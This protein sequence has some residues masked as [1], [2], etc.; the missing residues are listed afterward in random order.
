MVA[1]TWHFFVDTTELE[2]WRIF[3][4]AGAAVRDAGHK[5]YVCDVVLEEFLRHRVEAFQDIGKKIRDKLSGY[6]QI[7]PAPG[8]DIGERFRRI[9]LEKLGE[10]TIFRALDY[11]SLDEIL[12]RE[13]RGEKPFKPNGAGLRDCVIL[14][15]SLNY[16]RQYD[17]SPCLFVSDN[18]TDFSGDMVK[19][20]G[21]ERG[22]E[23]SFAAKL[24]EALAIA[25]DPELAKQVTQFM[26]KNAHTVSLYLLRHQLW[27]ADGVVVYG[28]VEI[29]EAVVIGPIATDGTCRLR[30][31][32]TV[33][34]R[35]K[36]FSPQFFAPGPMPT[37]YRGVPVHSTPQSWRIQGEATA[38]YQRGHFVKVS[39]IE[40]VQLA[41][42]SIVAHEDI[43][44]TDATDQRTSE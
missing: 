6:A 43:P 32:A 42:I 25:T 41:G 10:I 33:R 13:F 4:A 38:I 17:I 11:A 5:L 23:W 39:R 9:T 26:Q 40:A 24:G 16:A 22:Q 14:F 21:D 35:H 29:D 31:Y 8:A 37:F 7:E 28:D 15:A 44:S 27:S 19:R 30:F 3:G 34:A 36:Q 1:R 18:T 20:L 2:S 12:P